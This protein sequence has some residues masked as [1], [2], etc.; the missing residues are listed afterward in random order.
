MPVGEFPSSSESGKLMPPYVG[1][2]NFEAGSELRHTT[3]KMRSSPLPSPPEEERE[4]AR[5]R[6]FILFGERQFMWTYVHAS[7]GYGG[8]VGC[9]SRNDFSKHALSCLPKGVS[10]VTS[11]VT[12]FR[13]ARPEIPLRLEPRCRTIVAFP[14]PMPVEKKQLTQRRST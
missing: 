10:L 3:P 2:H 5:R 9:Y 4:R 14:W 6:I 1:S 11:A 8:W 7:R 13:H 12:F